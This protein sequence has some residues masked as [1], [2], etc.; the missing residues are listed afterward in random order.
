MRS[1]FVLVLII[2]VALTSSASARRILWKPKEKPPVS[3]REAITLAEKDLGEN[4]KKYHCIRASL[5]KTFSNGDWEFQFMTTK[6]E[7][8]WMSVG[9][10]GK[11]RRSRDGFAY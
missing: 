5:A 4:A 11:V 7:T 8:M 3:L 1:R 9:S 2:L 6:G 10:D